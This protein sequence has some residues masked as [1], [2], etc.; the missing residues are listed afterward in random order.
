[1]ERKLPKARSWWRGVLYG[2]AALVWAKC[3]SGLGF[4]CWIWF[5]M[6]ADPPRAQPMAGLLWFGVGPALPI[7]MLVSGSFLYGHWQSL[8]EEDSTGGYVAVASIGLVGFGLPVGSVLMSAGRVSAWTMVLSLAV[9][10]AAVTRAVWVIVASGAAEVESAEK[11]GGWAVRWV[12]W[13]ALVCGVGALA[14]FGYETA[15]TSLSTSTDWWTGSAE[16]L[17][18]FPLIGPLVFFG[19]FVL[20]EEV[21]RRLSRAFPAMAKASA[22]AALV[23]SVG[24][25]LFATE[26]TPWPILAI[27][28]VTW[29]YQVAFGVA[30]TSAGD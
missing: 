28:A 9:H 18:M 16:W 30:V 7:A 27:C 29:S 20:R 11:A 19:Y 3:L 15:Q 14:F 12:E 22:C 17:S 23:G 4:I 8:N 13:A 1:M 6:T 25:A 26:P 24:P 10:V 5:E 21:L 2:F